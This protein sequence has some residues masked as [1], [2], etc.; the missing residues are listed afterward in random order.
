[1]DRELFAK[2]ISGI[3]TSI[4]STMSR[5]AFEYGA[6]N[7]GQGFPDFDGPE[8]IMA[9]AYKA[10]QTGKN[11]YAPSQGIISLRKAISAY[12]HKY[13]DL[14]WDPETEISI[15]AGATEALFAVMQAFIEPGDEVILFEPYYDSY[16]NDVILAGGAPKYVTLRKPDFEF[17][18]DELAKA[19]SEKTKMIIVNN[20]HNPTGKVFSLRELQFI[21]GLAR[22]FNFIVLGDEVYEFLTYGDSRHIPVASLPEFRDN[23]ITV[24]SCGKT[25]GMTGW[26]VGFTLAKPDFINAVQKVRQ[27]TTFAVNT[28]A[29]HAM[30]FAF[31]KLDE[32]LPEFQLLYQKKRDFIYASLLGTKFKPHF[33]NGSYF[34]MAD[35]PLELFKD[36]IEC[37]SELVKNYGVATIP[38]SVFYSASDEGSTMLRICFA[39]RDDTLM[40][41][42]E[43]L[44]TV[45]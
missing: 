2:R 45:K 16:H 21:A 36:D 44:K 37:A 39:K 38:P 24:C 12:Q 33:P 13:Y 6:V 32:Y 4:F 41:G 31:G 7:L 11:Q 1:M 5:L 3:P 26:K 35:I 23:A 22:R 40:D 43:R 42:I 14:H 30:A 29:Q 34:I 25:F 8:W 9:E 17:D 18:F 19:V 28:P 10:M 20:P 27:W 15:S